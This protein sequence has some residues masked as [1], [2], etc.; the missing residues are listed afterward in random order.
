MF[1]NASGWYFSRSKWTLGCDRIGFI[2]RVLVLPGAHRIDVAFVAEAQVLQYPI[3]QVVLVGNVLVE[4][5][6][7]DPLAR[8]HVIHGHALDAQLPE[9]LGRSVQDPAPALIGGLQTRRIRSGDLLVGHYWGVK[10]KTN[11]TL[12]TFPCRTR[13][14]RSSNKNSGAVRLLVVLR[15]DRASREQHQRS[16]ARRKPFVGPVCT[17]AS[18]S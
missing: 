4:R 13:F 8:S 16:S 12:E 10:R 14:R 7:G 5:L 2:D 17:T 1:R 18:A 15:H 9:D 6:L 11:N 3:H